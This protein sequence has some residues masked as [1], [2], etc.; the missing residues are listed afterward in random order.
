MTATTDLETFV[1]KARAAAAAPD[2]KAATLAL[3]ARTFADP[4]ALAAALPEPEGEVCLFEDDT[5]SIWHERFEPDAELPPHNHGMPAFLGVYKGRERNRLWHLV[6]GI[7][8]PGGALDL[9][10]G[11]IHAFGP[12]DVHSVIALDGAPSFGLH[13][14]LGPLRRIDRS[15]YD[16]DT[17]A[18]IPMT[19]AAFL[20]MVRHR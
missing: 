6:D 10:S 7:A 2:A 19:E 1:T 16:W 11:Q 12:D 14:Y 4:D 13:I 17:G 5:A 15:L 8:R 3:M 18:P 20:S 9:T